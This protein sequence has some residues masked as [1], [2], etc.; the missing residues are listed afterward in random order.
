MMFSWA[1]FNKITIRSA[2][3]TEAFIFPLELKASRVWKTKKL[4]NELS[5]LGTTC[6]HSE[7]VNGMLCIS[8]S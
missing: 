1:L 4:K 7:E 6:T 2:G 5:S 8:D 3:I